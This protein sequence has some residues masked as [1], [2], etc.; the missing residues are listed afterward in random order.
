VSHSFVSVIS[1]P[2]HIELVLGCFREFIQERLRDPQ[3]LS[4]ADRRR[5]I[6]LLH[7]IEIGEKELHE[8]TVASTAS[9]VVE[10]EVKVSEVEMV[11]D[12]DVIEDES[13]L[14]TSTLVTTPTSTP[15]PTLL[16]RPTKRSR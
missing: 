14:E 3:N 1:E 6:F 10:P 11:A 5:R 13:V 16:K 12:I 8:R 4:L 9:E 7:A 15:T 2:E